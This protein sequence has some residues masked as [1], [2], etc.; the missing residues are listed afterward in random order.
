MASGCECGDP[1]KGFQTY[2]FVQNGVPRCFTVFHPISRAGESLPVVISSQCYGKD[3]LMSISMTND[4]AGDNQAAARYGYARIGVST[5]DGHWTF[6]NNNVVNDLAPMPCSDED[7]KDIAYIRKVFNFIESNPDKFDASRVYAEGFSQ[8]SMFSAYIGFCFPDNVVGIWQGGSG[9]A[10]TGDPINLPGCQ[11]QVTASDFAN[12]CA[13]CNAC[14]QS[15]P[16]T[17]CQ[18]WPIYPCYSPKRPMVNCLSE[19]TNDFISND[20]QGLGYSTGTNMYEKML[21]EGHD[22]RLLRF[23]PSNDDTIKGGHQD[24]RNLDYW[25]VGCMGITA[26]CSQ[27]CETAFVACVAGEDTSTGMKQTEAFGTCMDADIFSGLSGCTVD[28][29]PTFGMLAASENPTRDE[30]KHFGA[31][32]NEASSKPATS[33]CEME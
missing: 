7:S 30:V 9:M 12:E 13:N 10:I 5:P 6:G 20:K 27:E 4:K 3:K 32:S 2:T 1:S 14:L 26:S 21:E 16:C 17:E 28:C 33:H 22:A 23:S 18:Y 19:Y 15:H 11:G 8:N 25:Q 24:P 29:A 31:G